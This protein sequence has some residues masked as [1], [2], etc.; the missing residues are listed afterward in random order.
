MFS[1]FCGLIQFQG[2]MK[3]KVLFQLFLLLCHPFPVVSIEDTA[4][5]QMY[6][7]K[8]FTSKKNN[9]KSALKQDSF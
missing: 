1:R 2:D 5:Y 4:Y 7:L 3:E 9:L 8:Y 6:Y